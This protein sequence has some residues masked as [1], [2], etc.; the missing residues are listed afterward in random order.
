MTATAVETA[1]LAAD[2]ALAEGI[3]GARR[4]R[5]PRAVVK[6]KRRA[7]GREGWNNRGLG[8]L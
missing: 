5:G 3:I 4:Q 7:K 2:E 8:L 1:A 6:G